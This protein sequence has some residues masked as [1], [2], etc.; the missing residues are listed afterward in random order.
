MPRSFARFSLIALLLSLAPLPLFAAEEHDHGPAKEEPAPTI[1]LDKAPRIVEFQ[2]KQ[3]TN[4]QLL[5]LERKTDHI[6]YAPIY[7]ALLTRAGIEPKIR[8]E[9]IEAMAKLN[10]TDVATQLVAA[11]KRIDEDTDEETL[12]PRRALLGDLASMLLRE[13][14]ESLTALRDDLVSLAGDANDPRTKETGYAA[15]LIA[16]GAVEQV[17]QL[18][19]EKE[20]GQRFLFGAAALLKDKSLLAALYPVAETA[21]KETSDDQTRIAAIHA[22]SFVPGK[23]A[24]AFAILAGLITEGTQGNAAASALKRIPAKFWPQTGVLPVAKAIVK[25]LEEMPA[26]DRTSPAAID[27]VQLGHE[28]AG[29]L[30][31]E[32]AGPIKKALSALGVRVIV[33]KAPAEQMVFD[34]KWFAVE[35]GKP[36]QIIFQNT[37]V[38]PHNFVLVSPGSLEEIGMAAELMQPSNDPAVK[39]FV[40]ASPKVLAAMQLVQI[41]QTGRLSFNAPTEPGEYPYV[42]TYPGHWRRMYGVMVV[43]KDLEAFE[44]S[45]VE[46]KD[47]LGNTRSLVKVWTLDDLKPKLATVEK[48]GDAAKGKQIFT[49]AGCGLCHKMQGQGGAVGPE[50]TEVFKKWKGNREDVLREILEPSKV[51]DEKFR[52][53]IL[54]TNEGDRLFG[55]VTEETADAVMIVTNP[56]NPVPQKVAK[57]DIADRTKGQTSMMPTGLLN[58]FKDQEIVDLMKYLESG[59]A[60]KGHDH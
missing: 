11:I 32:E 12:E 56:Q 8:K 4:K 14:K 13:K 16:D 48:T 24:D 37:D 30:S 53:Q 28:L 50:L 22:V 6:K 27:A 2:L 52:P 59:G 18:T 21:I 1:F 35:A 5:S 25:L 29:K 34:Q 46:P 38:M 41:G 42:C 47:P 9:A 26:D 57:S 23:E 44:K 7:F 40:P 39:Q 55:L 58:I 49:E 51:I 20:N 17:V 45:P 31:A 60:A 36:V 43:V 54:E 19:T 33:L 3:L 10:K 15:M